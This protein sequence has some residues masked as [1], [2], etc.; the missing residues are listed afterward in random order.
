LIERYLKSQNKNNLKG[1]VEFM[2][3]P[4][5]PSKMQDIIIKSKLK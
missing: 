4:I 5:P 1:Y 3:K 2:K